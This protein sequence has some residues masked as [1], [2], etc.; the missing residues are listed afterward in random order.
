MISG[1]DDISRRNGRPRCAAAK[2]GLAILV[3]VAATLAGMVSAKAAP[4]M[5]AETVMSGLA[6]PRGLTFG[7]DGTLYVAEA[8]AGGNGAV[9][10][11][12]SG[13]QAGYGQ[14]G[15]I[16]SYHNGVQQQVFSG[17]PSLAPVGGQQAEGPN[18]V[19][20]DASGNLYAAIGLGSNPAN[21]DTTL[22]PEP[23]AG[24]LG[25]VAT[26]ASGSL[27]LFADLAA[28]E[29]ANDPDGAGP[30]SNPFSLVAG[31]GGFF[32]ADAGANAV[33]SIGSGG[34][35]AVETV[36]AATPNPIFPGFGGPT[37]QA[38]PTGAALASSGEFAFGQLTGF[39]FLQDAAQVFALDS[40]VL[41]VLASGLTHVID[42]AFDAN[43][44]L[45]AL[46]LDS[47]GLLGPGT[48]G[49]LYEVGAGGATRLLFDDLL[50]PT[51][52]TVGANGDFY[53]SV[54]G[55]SPTDGSVVRLAPVPLPAALPVFAGSLALLACWR[56]FKPQSSR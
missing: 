15:A 26:F 47:D 11:L 17:L 12:G 5:V 49:A 41:S 43:G 4:L 48:T 22:A 19:A 56:R 33:L 27:Q 50:N 38:V 18:E 21:R 55:F 25:T 53:V 13:A 16:S 40:G 7:P 54:N 35:I 28:F 46:E 31:P 24:L 37:Y 8:G 34:S 20:F 1:E 10:M 45:Y 36:L 2:A 32:A 30:D 9:I 23:G 6:N 51:G 52:L 44:T 29:A 14:T 3:S 42:V 39:P